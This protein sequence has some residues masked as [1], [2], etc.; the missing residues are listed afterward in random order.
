MSLYLF[1]R[2]H[3]RAGDESA[4]EEA[5]LEV[6]TASGDEPGCLEINAYRSIRDPLEFYIHS[7]WKT[8]E[9]FDIHASL[10]HTVRFI[11]RV[12]A[13]IDNE[14]APALTEKLP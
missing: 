1:A 7:R 10:P 3:A 11:E 4:L 8:R 5:I 6:V 12:K 13:L 9:A 14:F 2:F